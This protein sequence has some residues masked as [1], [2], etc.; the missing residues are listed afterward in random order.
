MAESKRD[1]R[2]RIAPRRVAAMIWA[3]GAAKI[4]A[5][6]RAVAFVVAYLI[7]SQL[8]LFRVPLQDALSLALGVGATIVGLALFLEGLF[9]GIM[10][11]GE[12]CGL[13]LPAKA[14]PAAAAAFALVVGVTATLAEPA[15]GILRAQGSSVVPWEA[16]LLYFLLNRGSP[17]LVGAV[18]AGVGIAVVAGV[19]R[20]LYGWSFKPFVFLTV[21]FL[22]AAGFYFQSRPELRAVAGL[23]WDTGGVTTGPVTV[24]LVI[25][26]GVGVS[27]ITG[28]RRDGASGL[29]VVTLAS[30]LPVAAVFAL[31]LLV[32]PLVPAPSSPADFFSEDRETRVRAEF[33]A[34]GE[35]GLAALAE[36]AAASGALSS[37][38]LRT[39]FPEGGTGPSSAADVAGP[40]TGNPG[41]ETASGFGALA[42][43]VLDALVAVLP[44]AL[45]L[46]VTLSVFLRERIRS[47][48]EVVLGLAFAVAGLFLF[49]FGME[50]GLSALGAQAG[51]SL[52]RAYEATARTDK[53]VLVAGADA[54]DKVT[55]AGPEGGKTYLW[56]EA[57]EGPALVPFEPGNLDPDSGLYRHVPV[58]RAIFGRWGAFA[59]VAAVLGFVFILGFGATL[60][61]PSLAALGITVEELTTGTYRKAGLVAVVAVGVGIGMAAGFARILYDL[62]LSWVLGIPY[63]LALVLTVF[64]SE[65]FAAIAWDAA[66]VTTG[67]VTVPLVIA[68]G[69]GIGSRS[70][71]SGAFAV[72]ACASVFPVLAVLLSGLLSAA[73]AKRS[74]GGLND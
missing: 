13:R 35:A 53:A 3:Y 5:Q 60:A 31:A 30:A 16:P 25:A 50:R 32:A 56:I 21:P 55:V 37:E 65:D 69:I 4:S 38:A 10:P 23:A 47:A 36:S 20:F 61:E 18:A 39:A 57:A 58:E 28:G 52:P 2:V 12:Q 73:R 34:G 63:A 74:V 48:D 71:A 14:G 7:L 9:L 41:P 33:L 54:A 43:S 62:P 24:P 19:F 17:L 64:S 27:R 70:G 45:V 8:F 29:G 72:V 1:A 67:P 15:I 68:A 51:A 42:G 66:G 22:V 46:V 49:N 6:A 40:E 44:L 11:L 26:L 59:G